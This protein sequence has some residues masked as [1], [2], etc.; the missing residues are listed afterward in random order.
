MYMLKL[1][2][3][4]GMPPGVLNVV[5]GGRPTVEFL[6]DAPEIRAISFVG[7]DAAG[8]AI[9]HVPLQMENSSNQFGC[10]KSRCHPAGSNK[11]ATQC[12]C[13]A[14]FWGSWTTL[15]GLV[16]CNF[17]WGSRSLDP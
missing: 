3:E 2:E 11:N 14:A 4:A 8:K 5:H 13:G 15:H 9:L 6:C 7:G 12:D 1:V 10:Q 17:R 16:S